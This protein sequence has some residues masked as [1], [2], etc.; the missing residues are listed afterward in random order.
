[1]EL[2]AGFKQHLHLLFLVEIALEGQKHLTEQVEEC[3]HKSCDM[4]AIKCARG[5]VFKTGAARRQVQL[6]RGNRL[7][8]QAAALLLWSLIRLCGR[9]GLRVR[10]S[11]LDRVFFKLWHHASSSFVS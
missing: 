2:L 9:G 5:A 1:M 8:K 6:V 3:E 7:C 4:N 10:G 11:L